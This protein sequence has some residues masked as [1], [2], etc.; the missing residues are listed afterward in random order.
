MLR[1]DAKIVKLAV[2]LIPLAAGSAFAAGGGN[3]A[4]S[5]A[6][7]EWVEYALL[8][9]FGLIGLI[10]VREIVILLKWIAQQEKMKAA[11]AGKK[12]KPPVEPK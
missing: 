8:A 3:G 6:W 12:E 11:E 4:A 1:I 2:V 10:G 9:A 5:A 7:K